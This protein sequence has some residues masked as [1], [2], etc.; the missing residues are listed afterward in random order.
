MY[1]LHSIIRCPIHHKELKLK[2]ERW[3]CGEGDSYPI[4]DGISIFLVENE[5]PTH[6]GHFDETKNAITGVVNK[7][8]FEEKDVDLYVQKAILG[9]C[10]I[11]YKELVGKL[12]RYPIPEIPIKDTR[13]KTILDVGCNWGR[14]SIS[15]AKRGFIP[16]GIDPSFEAVRAARRTS[17]K[18]GFEIDYLVA[19]ARHL[20]F[21]NSSFDIVFSYSVFQHFA[22]KDTV[23]SLNEIR[24]V[25]NADGYSL[26]QMLS[27]FGLR[28]QYHLIK[29]RYEEGKD[30]EVRY[31]TPWELKKIF[32]ENIGPSSLAIDGFFSANAQLTDRDILPWKYKIVVLLSEAMKRIAKYMPFFSLIADSLYVKSQLN[33]MEIQKFTIY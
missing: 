31:W 10:G 28:S 6:R 2:E 17:R 23:T 18:L 27:S 3:M 11:M 14:W 20:P 5:T 1:R 26:I 7:L 24:R 13:G 33:P 19:D 4:I 12:K 25:L 22:K 29:R 16:T 30:F 21:A 8:S 15:A 9:T 32:M